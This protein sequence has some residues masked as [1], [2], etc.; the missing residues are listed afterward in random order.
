MYLFL[1]KTPSFFARKDA[2]TLR[3]SSY[4]S[5]R[6]CVQQMFFAEIGKFPVP[7]GTR[8]YLIIFFL[9]IFSAYGTYLS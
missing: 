1:A 7:N 5:L 4:I 8:F 9:P 3:V 2:K 6:L